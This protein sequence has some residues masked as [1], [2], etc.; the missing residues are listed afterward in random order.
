MWVGDIYIQLIYYDFFGFYILWIFDYDGTNYLLI[1]WFFIC[2]LVILSV[3]PIYISW[4]KKVQEN[5]YHLSTETKQNKKTV[6]NHNMYR[7]ND[8]IETGKSF[9]AFF[10]TKRDNDMITDLICG[11]QAAKHI[12]ASSLFYDCTTHVALTRLSLH[13]KWHITRHYSNY[14]CLHQ[15]T[16]RISPHH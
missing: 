9:V 5:V 2:W 11:N 3:S 4:N 15:I 6:G 1:Q 16:C 8:W 12:A 14:Q 7:L 13:S 10:P